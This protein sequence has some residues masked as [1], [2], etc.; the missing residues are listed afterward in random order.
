M[1]N[2][3]KVDKKPEAATPPAPAPTVAETPAPETAAP[4]TA[5]A[6]QAP[7]GAIVV[8]TLTELDGLAD[9][10]SAKLTA[11]STLLSGGSLSDTS[12]AQLQLLIEQANPIKPGMEEVNTRWTVSRIVLCQPTT[13]DPKKP[14]MARPGDLFTTSGQLLQKPFGFIPLYFNEE[15]I[16]FKTGE[17]A[18]EC[19]APDAKLGSAYGL[20]LKCPHLPLGKQNGGRG[21]QEK[22]N[23]QNQIVVALVSADF[24]N[25]YVVQFGKTSRSAGSALISL[26]KAQPYP[27]KQKYNL[28]T[29]KETSDLGV[30]WT[31]KVEP[32]GK[33]NSPE[34]QAIAKALSELYQANRKQMLGEYYFKA[35][36]GD[37]AA[38]ISEQ[39]FVDDAKLEAGL[40]GGVEPDLSG[41]TSSPGPN[42]RSSA[43]PM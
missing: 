15:N 6:T 34:E 38:A 9:A 39:S 16:M 7:K 27:W 24:S 30:Y 25:V 42:V 11:L 21:K 43:K 37:G 23:C 33:D 28:V 18:P 5:I 4:T 10:A 19:A 22:T 40:K 14:E 35:A 17:K 20:C 29:Q 41:P 13:N 31:L 32:T 36:S 26:A 12:K 3:K 1:A 8:P 2:D